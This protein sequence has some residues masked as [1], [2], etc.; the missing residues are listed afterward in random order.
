MNDTASAEARTQRRNRLQLAGIFA[1]AMFSLGLSYFLFFSAQD[2]GVWGTTNEG[3]WVRPAVAAESLPLVEADGGAVAAS[4]HWWLWVVTDGPCDA[5]CD[6]AV[7]EMRQL[8]VLLNKEADRVRRALVAPDA[9]SVILREAF[10]NLARW[11]LDT[12][13]ALAAGIYV[14]DPLGNLVFRYPVNS[15]GKPVLKDLKRLLKVS[16]IG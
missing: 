6:N 10:P 16:Q 2:G 8:H 11:R 3:E 1:I 14:I 7:H 4:A 9:G 13:G 12:P 15:A 5:V